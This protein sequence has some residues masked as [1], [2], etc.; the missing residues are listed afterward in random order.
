MVCRVQGVFG[1]AL[2]KGNAA[3]FHGVSGAADG[4]IEPIVDV[5]P[6]FAG[7]VG[8]TE[9]LR[10]KNADRLVSAYSR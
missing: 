10:G 7:P 9:K 2:K 3:A 8:I 4:D 6:L 5:E 1:A